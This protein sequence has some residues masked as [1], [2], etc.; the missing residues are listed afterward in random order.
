MGSAPTDVGGYGGITIALVLERL[1]N[2]EEKEKEEEDEKESSV[3]LR[4][5]VV[6]HPFARRAGAPDSSGS[7]LEPPG[8][9]CSPFR[10]HRDHRLKPGHRTGSGARYRE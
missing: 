6:I 10:V 2:G 3:V 7:R 9:G 8:A 1:S 5:F 4:V